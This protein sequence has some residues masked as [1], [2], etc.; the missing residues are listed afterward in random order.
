MDKQR[1]SFNKD[2]VDFVVS[3]YTLA[4]KCADY[5]SKQHR[6]S[7]SI[8]STILFLNDAFCRGDYEQVIILLKELFTMT[9]EAT[10]QSKYAFL[11]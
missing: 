10:D 2:G 5:A 8:K 4:D 3:T 6:D 9:R 11:L 1:K 7:G